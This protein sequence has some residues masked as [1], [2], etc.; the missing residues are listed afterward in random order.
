MQNAAQVI[1]FFDNQNVLE[2]LKSELDN[3]IANL[4]VS[5]DSDDVSESDEFKFRNDVFIKMHSDATLEEYTKLV[6]MLQNKL[7]KGEQEDS[8][9]LVNYYYNGKYVC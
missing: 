3:T 9:C 5:I 1:F 2:A 7:E 6:K 4:D 8:M